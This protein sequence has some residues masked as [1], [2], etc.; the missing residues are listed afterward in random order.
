MESVRR[1]ARSLCHSP[2]DTEDLVQDTYLRAYQSW[3]T[4]QP[5]TDCRRWLFTICRNVFRRQCRDAPVGASRCERT[6][7][8]RDDVGAVVPE[9]ELIDR[10][11]GDDDFIARLDFTAAMDIALSLVPEPYRSTFVAV[12]VDDQTYEAAAAQLQVPVGTVRS[13]LFRARRIVQRHL[14]HVASDAGVITVMSM[15]PANATNSPGPG[16]ASTIACMPSSRVVERRP[17]S[18]QR[19]KSVCETPSANVAGNNQR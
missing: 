4:F 9:L 16:R 13:R 12:L 18:S 15:A 1:F 8:R 11:Q 2:T 17:A 7:R 19:M 5:G 3:H 6:S 14:L 10:S